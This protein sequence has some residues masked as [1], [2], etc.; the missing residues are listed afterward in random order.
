MNSLVIVS[1][2][3]DPY[4]TTQR[5]LQQSSLPDLKG[6]RILLKPNAARLALPGQ[7][8]TTHPS[9]IEATIDHFRERGASDI[10]VGESCIFGVDAQEAF[11]VTG[12]K[13]VC[14]KKGVRLI[15]FDDLDST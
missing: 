7:G 15:N 4:R 13:E 3:V 5:A 11:R 10:A 14:E 9:V 2:G 12:M 8:V 1:K 6:R